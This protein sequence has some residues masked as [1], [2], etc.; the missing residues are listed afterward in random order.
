MTDLT[1][2]TTDELKAEIS[3]REREAEAAYWE[4]AKTTAKWL[5]P[6]CGMPDSWHTRDCP[7]DTD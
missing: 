6:D 4:R 1:S 3:R 5:C 7:S 2:A